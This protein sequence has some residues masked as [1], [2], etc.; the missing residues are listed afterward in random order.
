MSGVLY[1]ESSIW[2]F[3]LV[4][5]L[6][7]GGAAWLS[8]RAVALTWRPYW[9]VLWYVLL[10]ACAVRFL[11]FALFEGTLLSLRY[12]LADL[13]VLVIFCTIGFRLTRVWQMTTQYPWLY[14]RTNPF[15]WRKREVE[16]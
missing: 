13:G 10:L 1:E 3:L 2:L 4:T 16:A 12:Y 11:H 6:L 14:E 5:V 7:G 9:Q 8:G 15:F